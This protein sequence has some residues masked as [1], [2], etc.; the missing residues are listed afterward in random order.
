MVARK[1]ELMRD[2][3]SNIDK[4]SV[5]ESITGIDR[6]LIIYMNKLLECSATL[7]EMEKCAK[8]GDIISKKYK[9][10]AICPT[11]VSYETDDDVDAFVEG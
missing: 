6:Y 4:L 5:V 3:V 1:I 2:D 10:S 11:N 7:G 9:T 8:I